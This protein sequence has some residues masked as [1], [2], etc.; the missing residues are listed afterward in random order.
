MLFLVVRIYD[1]FGFK[2]GLKVFAKPLPKFNGVITK[3]CNYFA[4]IYQ[5]D[6]VYRRFQNV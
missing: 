3:T 1:A 6:G 5:E 2:A 4:P